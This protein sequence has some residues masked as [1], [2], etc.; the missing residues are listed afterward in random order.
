MAALRTHLQNNH[1][2]PPETT[3]KTPHQLFVTSTTLTTDDLLSKEWIRVASRPPSILISNF[4][5][6]VGNKR[7]NTI[8][9]E[10][11]HR[12]TEQVGK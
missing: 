6:F 2:I 9:G 8:V 12:H 3:T 1:D 10:F 7:A 5:I 11:G 4:R